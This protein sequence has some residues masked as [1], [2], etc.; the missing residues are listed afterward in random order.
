[1][2]N[3][4]EL[5][6]FI[7]PGRVMTL[8]IM[9]DGKEIGALSFNVDTLAYK[10]ILETVKTTE[11]VKV[12]EKPIEKKSEPIKKDTKK[13]DKNDKTG[14]HPEFNPV[15][16][17]EE[18]HVNKIIE[19]APMTRESVLIVDNPEEV[20]EEEEVDEEIEEVNESPTLSEEW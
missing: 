9:I 2:I 20:E 19:N 15:P 6:K 12:A 18:K 16:A 13:A 8:V 10:A 3:W 7:T 4:K 11:P 1:M 5:E 17:H 14:K